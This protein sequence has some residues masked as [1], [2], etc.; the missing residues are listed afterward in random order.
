MK[1]QVP[2][3]CYT[4]S[5]LLEM[6]NKTATE[7]ALDGRGSSRSLVVYNA[8]EVSADSTSTPARV[9]RNR[10]RSKAAIGNPKRNEFFRLVTDP[11]TKKTGRIR[12]TRLRLHARSKRYFSE[13]NLGNPGHRSGQKKCKQVRN[14]PHSQMSQKEKS[15]RAL[16][17]FRARNR[18]KES[19]RPDQKTNRRSHDTHTFRETKKG[20]TGRN[21]ASDSRRM[22]EQNGD[23][24]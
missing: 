16:F 4:S 13:T 10:V 2:P 19:M 14:G 12:A 11:T 5:Y 7:I 6:Y 23:K 24:N 3:F 20:F 21:F 17:H 1:T 15:S 9:S 8:T 22:C 18:R